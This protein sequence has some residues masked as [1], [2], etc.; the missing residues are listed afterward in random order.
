MRIIGVG[1]AIVDRLMKIESD[2]ELAAM[3]L[4]KASMTM[5]DDERFRAV[6]ESTKA[7]QAVVVPGGAACNTIRALAH[8]YP[9]TGFIGKIGTD[10]TGEQYQ[11]AIADLGVETLL[12]HDATMPTGVATTFVSTDGERTFATF[13][14]A[15]TQLCPADLD[16]L[17]LDGTDIL[18]LEGYLVYN[19]PLMEALARVARERGIRMAFDMGSYNMVEQYR[20]YLTAYIK[21]NVSILFANEEEALAL[22]GMTAIEALG[23]IGEMVDTVVVKTG[24]KGAL[25]RDAAGSCSVPAHPVDRVQDTTGAGDFFAAGFFYGYAQGLTLERCGELGVL[26]A[27][28]VIQVVGPNLH[29]S[30][31]DAIKARISQ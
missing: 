15:S 5:I 23:A 2:A 13:L 4:P 8:L 27:T 28:E 24:A 9:G 20:D 29:P 30:Q 22:T 31:W 7:A 11:R 26:F 17:P 19:T 1:A 10:A 21:E 12:S 18:Y 25:L 3:E 16:A 6:N 14:G